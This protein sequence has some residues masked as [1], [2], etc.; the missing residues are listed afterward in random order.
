MTIKEA[1][2]EIKS[3]KKPYF[4]LKPIMTQGHFSSM[5]IRAENGLLKPETLKDF[6]GKFGYDVSVQMNAELIEKK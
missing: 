2:L 3:R 4:K 6:L 5:C 1:I